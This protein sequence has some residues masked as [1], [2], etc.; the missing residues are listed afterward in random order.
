[1]KAS[2]G[3]GCYHGVTEEKEKRYLFTVSTR[4]GAAA[5]SGFLGRYRCSDG[6]AGIGLVPP[7]DTDPRLFSSSPCSEVKGLPCFVFRCKRWWLSC[8]LSCPACLMFIRDVIQMADNHL[9]VDVSDIKL[10]F[11]P[12]LPQYFST[13]S[14]SIDSLMVVD[15]CET[16]ESQG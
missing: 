13:T 5:P 7:L 12:R 3:I 14:H 1:M 9:I 15:G 8:A 2:A 4:K 16:V 11:A 6:R 10:G